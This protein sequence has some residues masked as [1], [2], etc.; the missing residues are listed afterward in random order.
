MCKNSWTRYIK[1]DV[2]VYELFVVQLNKCF[3]NKSAVNQ[4]IC[5]NFRLRGWPALGYNTNTCNNLD[6]RRFYSYNVRM[7]EC[8]NVSKGFRHLR[9]VQQY[10]TV[11]WTVIYCCTYRNSLKFWLRTP[12]A[13]NSPSNYNECLT[14]ENRKVRSVFLIWGMVTFAI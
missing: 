8:T 13:V 9:Y 5:K 12:A 7:Y 4:I 2:L 6:L 3:V 11:R 10:L 14:I 1:L